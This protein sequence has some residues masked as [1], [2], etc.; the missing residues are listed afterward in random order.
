VQA[1]EKEERFVLRTRKIAGVQGEDLARIPSLIGV[2]LERLDGI[3]NGV[4]GYPPRIRF[5]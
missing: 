2:E 1:S 5:G 4:T 3:S